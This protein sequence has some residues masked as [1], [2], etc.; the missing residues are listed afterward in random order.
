MAPKT[1]PP[2]RPDLSDLKSDLQN[3]S[4][5]CN[6]TALHHPMRRYLWIRES[7]GES[8]FVRRGIPSRDIGLG[9]FGVDGGQTSMYEIW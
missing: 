3:D 2:D 9:R 7:A 5:I 4:W 6:S 1:E 8:G